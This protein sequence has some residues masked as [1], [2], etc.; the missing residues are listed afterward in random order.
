MTGRGRPKKNPLP[1]KGDD[2]DKTVGSVETQTQPQPGQAIKIKL[3]HKVDETQYDRRPF[4]LGTMK[5][6]P[7]QNVTIGGVQFHAF[8]ERVYDEKG[9][10]MTQRDKQT[11]GIAFLTEEKVEL[12]KERAAQ[13]IVRKL[14]K[15]IVRVY[16][17]A[18]ERYRY[19]PGDEPLAKYIYM[20][21]LKAASQRG[22]F[23]PE[24]MLA[25]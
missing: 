16:S 17:T 12:I 25:E 20:I 21:P 23:E 19:E 14:G 8:T 10:W 6:S 4:W 3:D 7:V 13:K 22:Q 1:V 15:R 5:N 18:S 11:G 24:P 9:K 2:M